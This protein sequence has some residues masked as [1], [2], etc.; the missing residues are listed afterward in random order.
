MTHLRYFLFTFLLAGCLLPVRSYAQPAP[1]TETVTRYFVLEEV[2][3]SPGETTLGY[4]Y[5]P[6]GLQVIAGRS[7]PVTVRLLNDDPRSEASLGTGLVLQRLKGKPY[8][9][10]ALFNTHPDQADSVF[11][12]RKGDLV[13]LPVI[14]PRRTEPLL[15]QL[16]DLEG[17]DMR[18]NN[19]ER[20]VE[21]DALHAVHP[22]SWEDSL[23]RLMTR[24]VQQAAANLQ[25]ADSA[26]FHT[27]MQT[28]R[29]KGLTLAQALQRCR[30]T[31]LRAFFQY[32]L[33]YFRSYRGQQVRLSESFAGWIFAGGPAGD[34][35]VYETLWPLLSKPA[36][37][38]KKLDE[39]K[40]LIQEDN[41]TSYWLRAA[42]EAQNRGLKKEAEK[43]LAVTRE[44]TKGISRPLKAGEYHLAKAQFWQ[45]EKRFDRSIAEADSALWILR[46][47]RD[48]DYLYYQGLLKKAYCYRQLR[49]WNAAQNIYNLALR[50]LALDTLYTDSLIRG[51]IASRIRREQG[52]GFFEAE[53]YDS[54]IAAYRQSAEVLR[55]YTGF[56]Q[57]GWLA[58]TQDALATAYEKQNRN[59]EAEAIYRELVATYQSQKD[60]MKTME[61][62]SN[63]AFNQTRQ[64]EYRKAIANYSQAI[65]FYLSIEAWDKAGFNH[66]Q[67]GQCYWSL[68]LYDSAIYHHR[69]ALDYQEKA[70]HNG[71]KAYA[72]SKLGNLYALSGQTE[73]GLEAL[74]S[75]AR[76]AF[77]DRDTLAG[78]GYLVEA[79]EARLE[80]GYKPAALEQFR[81]AEKLARLSGR[82][83]SLL[84]S[85][86][87]LAGYYHTSDSLR[88]LDYYG[89]ALELADQLGDQ[90]KQI[91]TLLNR[92]LLLNRNLRYLE[93]E[94]EVRRAFA[95]ARVQQNAFHLADCY[96]FLGDLYDYRLQYDSSYDSYRRSFALFDSLQNRQQTAHLLRRMGFVNYSKGDIDAAEKEFRSSLET[97][98]QTGNEQARMAA[99]SA[100]YDVHRG[101]GQMTEARACLDSMAAIQERT[102]DPLQRAALALDYSVYYLQQFEQE[103]ALRFLQEADSIYRQAGLREMR[104]ICLGHTGAIYLRQR[105]NDKA[106]RYFNEA[107]SVAGNTGIT[108]DL[109]LALRLSAAEALFNKKQYPDALRQA[110]AVSREARQSGA[111]L[112]YLEAQELSGMIALRQ[113]NLVLARQRLEEAVRLSDA[114]GLTAINP[115]LYLARTYHSEKK[116][117]LAAPL[118]TR[119]ET[120]ARQT[121]R[122]N[123][124]WE[125]LYE[126]GNGF[127]LEG[128]YDSAVHFYKEAVEIVIRITPR[129]LG[130]EEEKNRLRTEETRADLF[131]Q[132]IA[133]SVRAGK[134]EDAVL[135]A[136]LASQQGIREK[137]MAVVSQDE[138]AAGLR[139]RQEEARKQLEAEQRRT[140]GGSAERMDALAKVVQTAEADYENYIDDLASRNENLR[141]SFT[142]S[143]NPARFAAYKKNI[144]D[145]VACLLYVHQG[146]QLYIF[147]LTR[148]ETRA[149]TAD[150]RVPLDSALGVFR[151]ILRNPQAGL[152][153]KVPAGE[154]GIW[155]SLR[156]GS[157]GNAG[158]SALLYKMLMGPVEELIRGKKTL[159]LI[160]TG[161]LSM[162]PFQALCYPDGGRYRYLLEDYQVF[163][164][165]QLEIFYEKDQPRRA[166]EKLSAFGNPDRSLPE[167]EREVI[168]LKNLYPGLQTYLGN[169]A[170]ETRARERLL[171]DRYLHFATHG[172]MDFNDF[173]NSYLTFAP[174]ASDPAFD[175]KLTIREIKSLRIEDCE[176]VTLS[177]CESGV[178]KEISRGWYISPA[179]SFL[180]KGVRS[181]I[182]SL[183]KVHDAATA[184]LM[185]TFY[186]LLPEMGKAEALRQAQLELMR[187]PAFR[188]PYYW[189]PFQL[190]GAWQ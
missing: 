81:Q 138:K 121:G 185:T 25:Q 180:V 159:C 47:T 83:Q 40:D 19:L 74:D 53:Q 80:A 7:G 54:A 34:R 16:L 33:T 164:T 43:L 89:K 12:A 102:G 72:W 122:V 132:L 45:D 189:S 139:A 37:F 116:Y 106:L 69:Q 182:A 84:L 131:N 95:I 64:G 168:N 148:E 79:G 142:E 133:A 18:N 46:G 184:R 174:D 29:Y 39:Y 190:F 128:Q 75:A 35:E 32:V 71:H 41:F 63:V 44:V 186:R 130:T 156:P 52:H 136:N 160:P 23:I 151:R 73:K 93:A 92:G 70:K 8:Y 14:V 31:D 111:Q 114:R 118:L 11:I 188:H 9:L 134:A 154:T 112:R 166:P 85:L 157:G 99:Y 141:I 125:V 87:H 22:A 123:D 4:I 27:P 104:L 42:F 28:G 6:E 105:D 144:P 117:P 77:L 82:K 170:T 127:F 108:T 113:N 181:V 172:V 2:V 38:R 90:D 140:G 36:M 146:A 13:A 15:L 165:S 91:Y 30:D 24:E 137:T 65:R 171:Q 5:A 20:F 66:S 183:W 173:R 152:P 120:Q 3:Y 163:Y 1:E 101:R 177:A 57:A 55:Q 179:N 150:L 56:Q 162:I 86:Y 149:V 48:A 67:T 175:G 78:I 100:M 126:K 49:Q 176:L 96:R 68:G 17:A 94:K 115:L 129:M 155:T 61:A 178:N 124:L 167:A 147:V 187:D 26:T 169:A 103:K 58:E 51:T 109:V 143:V 98:R 161:R 21:P 60:G 119:A 50:D 88:A 76:Y 97:A 110:E 153:E 10:L 158:L 59:R 62:V 135:Y 145:S 107:L